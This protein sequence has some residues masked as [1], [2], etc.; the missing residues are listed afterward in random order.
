MS[1]PPGSFTLRCLHARALGAYSAQPPN[2]GVRPSCCRI[3]IGSR[4]RRIM[5]A[6][7]LLQD[8]ATSPGGNANGSEVIVTAAT[9]TA[10]PSSTRR[11]CP[12]KSG[13]E[14]PSPR[15]VRP[16]G[17]DALAMRV[18]MREESH[19]DPRR[20]RLGDDAADGVRERDP[21]LL[22]CWPPHEVRNEA[23]GGEAVKSKDSLAAG[24]DKG[25][26][27]GAVLW[28]RCCCRCPAPRLPP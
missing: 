4:S 26:G 9:A 11:S 7:A 28:D 14:P 12:G 18:A 27:L 25:W 2:L 13:K 24:A 3:C 6:A 15:A 20:V 16:L 23:R 22:P 8:R 1:T 10:A 21:P 19:G 5:P 17:D